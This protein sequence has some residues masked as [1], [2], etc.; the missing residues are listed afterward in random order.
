ME[1]PLLRLYTRTSIVKDFNFEDLEKDQQIAVIKTIL[2]E[3]EFIGIKLDTK[4]LK[5]RNVY[6]F[7]ISFNK[8]I[9]EII[10]DLL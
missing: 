9:R 6:G 5:Y 2:T 1:N 7:T 4:N 8:S 10:I 3:S